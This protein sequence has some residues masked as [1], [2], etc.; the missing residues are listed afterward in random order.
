MALVQYEVPVPWRRSEGSD[1][2]THCWRQ[3]H[4]TPSDAIQSG[5]RRGD[6]ATCASS[7][8]A[9]GLR[10]PATAAG[11]ARAHDVQLIGSKPRAVA[12]SSVGRL[13]AA[14]TAISMPAA[15]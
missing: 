5:E 11:G 3:A 7:A 10:A 4:S 8:A 13:K 14:L 12:P 2:L 15:G 6:S 9:S 1:G